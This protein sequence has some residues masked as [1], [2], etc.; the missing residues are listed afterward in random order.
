[1]NG[2]YVIDTHNGTICRIWLLA[3]RVE[4]LP[5]ENRYMYIAL[6]YLLPTNLL[7]YLLFRAML[8][9]TTLYYITL[10]YIH[11]QCTAL[12]YIT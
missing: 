1:M 11:I 10:N 8:C 2:Q 6:H 3:G 7:T 5:P 12:Q 9:C 4:G